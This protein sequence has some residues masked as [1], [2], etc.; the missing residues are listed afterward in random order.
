MVQ[1]FDLSQRK[2]SFNHLNSNNL[3]SPRN[4]GRKQI[5]EYNPSSPRT[6]LS[7]KQITSYEGDPNK[8]FSSPQSKRSV[9]NL[10]MSS[11]SP[12]IKQQLETR[13]EASK[14]EYSEI[15]KLVDSYKKQ[16]ANAQN[17]INLTMFGSP[18]PKLASNPSTAKDSESHFRTGSPSNQNVFFDKRLRSP[19]KYI[20]KHFIL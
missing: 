4:S 10:S 8:N 13:L 2:E 15:S 1:P 19:D 16:T 6:N 11:Q 3:R 7:L 17:S 20:S 18:N 5:F 14:R 12:S 9:G